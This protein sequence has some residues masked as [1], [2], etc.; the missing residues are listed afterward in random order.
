MACGALSVLFLSLAT[1]L[2]VSSLKLPHE[3]CYIEA[4]PPTSRIVTTP[5]WKYVNADSLPDSFDW[6]SVNDTCLVSAVTNQFLPSPCGS[7]WA[8]ASTGALTD[9]IIIST[10]GRR[11]VVQLSPQVLLDCQNDQNQMGSCR[12]GSALKAYE[13]IHTSGIT[14]VSCSPYMAVDNYYW[15]EKDCG[16]IMCRKCDRFGNC[17][18][19][20]GTKYY[21]E[22]Y[23]SVI[24]E[25]QMMAE[26]YTRGPIACS[27]YAH[28]SAF[29]D[30]TSGVI[31][32]PVAYNYTTHV[33]AITGWGVD[34][35][36]G[37]KYWTGRNSFGTVWG[38][39]GWFKLQ[40][41]V[42]CLEIEKNICAWAVPKSV[43]L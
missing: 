9:R 27:V 18:F 12:G 31:Q 24:G 43:Q 2:H 35:S 3:G 34:G 36:S 19:V 21:T 23:G 7:C 37:I 11:S 29:E 4:M 25:A 22:E 1:L 14:D 5:P 28:S 13:F 8:L 41:G 15:A 30:Y 10:K 6:R 16:D 33:V 32:D 20:N 26:I 40:R 39:Q 38:E 17:K 42:N